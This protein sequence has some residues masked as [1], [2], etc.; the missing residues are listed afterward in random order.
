[1]ICIWQ[2]KGW[3]LCIVFR[4]LYSLFIKLTYM[5]EESVYFYNQLPATPDL[6]RFYSYVKWLYG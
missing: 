2:L 5:Y 3:M 6:Y 4:I 1:M